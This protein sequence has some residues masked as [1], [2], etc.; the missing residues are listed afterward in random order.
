MFKFC[1]NGLTALWAREWTDCLGGTQACWFHFFKSLCN[2]VENIWK[3]HRCRY[4]ALVYLFR[5]SIFSN[6]FL[7]FT[8]GSLLYIIVFLSACVGF[9][10]T[11]ISWSSHLHW[12]SKKLK[13][14]IIQ[15]LL[16]ITCS[17]IGLYFN[18]KKT[19]W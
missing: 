8:C 3:A 9:D 11:S 12:Y 18:P 14:K 10:F 2:L 4:S 16:Y 17:N 1:T 15:N 5:L 13:K 7:A 19:R 6:I